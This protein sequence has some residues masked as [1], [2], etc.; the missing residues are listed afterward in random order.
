[1]VEY[2]IVRAGPPANVIQRSQVLVAL[3]HGAAAAV[4]GKGRGVGEMISKPAIAARKGVLITKD[5][6]VRGKWSG[7]PNVAA[8]LAPR[9]P[10]RPAE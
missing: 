3:V 4:A 6:E 2:T 5:F 9:Q 8:L 10:V 1:M 7:G